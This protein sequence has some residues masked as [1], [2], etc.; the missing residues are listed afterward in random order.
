MSKNTR[1]SIDLN[2]SEIHVLRLAVD[3]ILAEWEDYQN[4][5]SSDRRQGHEVNKRVL[6]L[7]SLSRRF[8]VLACIPI[9]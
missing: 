2:E 1:L 9:P 3:S 7:K 4:A 6:L 5:P 8:A